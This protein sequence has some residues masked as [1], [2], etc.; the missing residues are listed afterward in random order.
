MGS[1]VLVVA[2]LWDEADTGIMGL[3]ASLGCQ[4]VGIGPGQDIASALYVDFKLRN[5]YSTHEIIGKS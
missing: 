1:S 4:V 3:A 2:L 5:G